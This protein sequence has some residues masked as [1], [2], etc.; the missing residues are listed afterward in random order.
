M[1]TAANFL[2]KGRPVI[3]T[4]PLG[5]IPDTIE[6]YVKLCGF[7]DEEINKLLRVCVIEGQY[8]EEV[9]SRRYVWSTK[10][11][12][13]LESMGLFNQMEAE[14]RAEAGGEAVFNLVGLD[15]VYG[16]FGLQKLPLFIN[17]G[18]SSAAAKG[19]LRLFI[20][21]PGIPSKAAYQTL[22][23][24]AEIHLRIVRKH[25][26]LF[27]Y[28][29]KPRTLLYAIEASEKSFVPKLVPIV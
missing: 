6:K 9:T 25:G 2:A 15:N 29:V 19:D 27:V 28:G 18:I 3:L 5:I 26:V 23:S 22:Y 11:I 10:P 14:L 4:L 8:P 12:D 20:L 17:R 13:I 24:T 1:A 7:T 21:K 16:M